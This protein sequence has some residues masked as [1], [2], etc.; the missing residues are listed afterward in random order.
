[1]KASRLL[2]M[3][4]LLVVEAT[5]FGAQP[6][7]QGSWSARSSAGTIFRGTWTAVP[8]AK[9]GAATG[10]WTLDDEKGKPLRRGAWS[11]AKSAK[12]WNGAWRATVSGREGEF[13]GTWTAS[14]EIDPNARFAE[15]FELAIKT[16]VSGS[17]RAGA[18]S[19]TWSIRAFER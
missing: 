13:S 17:W 1:V 16:V 5:A 14:A 2:V 11:A 18:Q 4:L 19:G 10:T 3:F 12:E 6:S 15:L 8:D 7:K 9:T